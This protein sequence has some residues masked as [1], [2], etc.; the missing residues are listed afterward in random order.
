MSH[1]VTKLK[2]SANFAKTEASSG[3][4]WVEIRKCETSDT[5]HESVGIPGP[6]TSKQNILGFHAVEGKLWLVERMVVRR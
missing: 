6:C 4:A 1:H 2:A 3:E 5:S